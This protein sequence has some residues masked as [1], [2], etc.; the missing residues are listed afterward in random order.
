MA[1]PQSDRF[2]RLPTELLEALLRARLSGTQWAIVCWVVRHALGWNRNTTPFSWYRIASDLSMDRGGV[3][4]AGNKLLQAGV[5]YSQDNQIG[6]QQDTRHWKRSKRAPQREETMTDVSADRCHPK[7]LTA[8]IPSDDH[9]QRERCQESS[10]L[11]RA[12]DR[13]KERRKTY[14]DRPRPQTDDLRNRLITA[15]NGARQH[16]AGAAR[17]IPGKY[18][19][20][21]EN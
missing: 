2:V 21:S 17:P 9:R 10:L 7:P 8:I 12:K 19:G 16:L 11:R 15:Q 6:V 5:L 3:V 1:T 14:I 20:L 13:S 18:D 4:R